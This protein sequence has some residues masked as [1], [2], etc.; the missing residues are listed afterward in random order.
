MAS[1][2]PT[3]VANLPESLNNQAVCVNYGYS[4]NK[5]NIP[6]PRLLSLFAQ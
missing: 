2:E 1:S 3:L 4:L 6:Q 5:E